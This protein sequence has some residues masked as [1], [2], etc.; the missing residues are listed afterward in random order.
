MMTVEELIEK[1]DELL[2]SPPYE[3][4]QRLEIK[5]T[6]DRRFISDVSNYTREGKCLST[7]QSH[8]ALK[9]IKRYKH[10]LVLSGYL[11]ISIDSILNNPTHRLPPYV[12]S[13]INREVRYLGDNK[14]VFRFKYNPPII[15]SIRNLRDTNIYTS[16][17]YPDF[18]KNLKVWTIEVTPNNYDNIITLISS[19]KFNFDDD[20]AIYF[21]NFENSKSKKSSA[22]II[23][24]KI[25]VECN[26]EGLFSEVLNNMLKTDFLNE[27]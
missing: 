8:L 11:D 27:L 21:M 5:A 1:L 9:L 14:L 10:H 13:Q 20:V 26:N 19:H 4:N 22:K 3:N 18:N 7:S 6:W 12:T 17:T 25:V 23:N 2:W 15:E 24:D 16:T